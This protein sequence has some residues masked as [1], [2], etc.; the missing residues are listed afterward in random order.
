MIEIIS[1][2]YIDFISQS[3]SLLIETDGSDDD[4]SDRVRVTVAGG[5]PVLQVS[6]AL[7]R[8]VPGDPDAAAP[9]GH[10]GTEV[11]DAGGLVQTS[12]SPLVVL[13]IVG[14]VGHD[15]S[16]V[17]PGEAVYG[18]LDH[19]HPTRLPHALSGEV[20]VGPGSVPVSLHGLRVEADHYPKVLSDPAE[21]VAGD[22]EVVAHLDALAGSDLVLPLC[23]HHLGVGAGDPDPGIETGA[24]V[25]LHNVPSVDLVCPHTA[26]VG[27]LGSGEPVLWPSEGV[28]VLVQQGVLLLD[29][30]PGV[31]PRSLVHHNLTRLPLVISNN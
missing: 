24:V 3:F 12:Q 14:V 6:V 4:L 9:V 2:K 10:P 7:L 5:S 20:A 26:V 17:E 21:E 15:V 8:H 22:P 1:V 29:T 19:L 13:A 11:V 30:E 25:S 31:L 16:L 23:G 27:T 28:L 18:L